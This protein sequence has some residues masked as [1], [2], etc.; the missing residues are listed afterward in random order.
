M[1][2]D[3]ARHALSQYLYNL[4]RAE[5][6]GMTEKHTPLLGGELGPL[7]FLYGGTPAVKSLGL[8]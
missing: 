1:H 4:A 6:L 3:G 5:E 2:G 7:T 8:I